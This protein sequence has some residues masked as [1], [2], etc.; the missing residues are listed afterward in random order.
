M[1]TRNRLA[2]C[3]LT[4]AACAL[5]VPAMAQMTSVGIDCS[6]LSSIPCSY[7]R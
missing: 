5:A 4:L 1:K 7:V 3:I 6:Q 2:I